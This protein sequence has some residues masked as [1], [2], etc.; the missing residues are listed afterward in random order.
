MKASGGVS[1]VGLQDQRLAFKWVQKYVH[2]FGGD[3]Q[4]V[5]VAGVSAGGASIIYH[6]TARGGRGK[7]PPFRQAVIQSGG[8]NPSINSNHQETTFHR[9]LEL[10]KVKTFQHAKK[11]SS[12]DLRNANYLATFTLN[13]G[14]LSFGT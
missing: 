11:V 9:F 5:T 10:L 3:P 4:R 13:W 6:I 2:L 12:L 1:N 7:P 8:G 14:E